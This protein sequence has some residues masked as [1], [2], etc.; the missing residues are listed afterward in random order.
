MLDFSMAMKEF[1]S[2]IGKLWSPSIGLNGE[3]LEKMLKT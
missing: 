1:T 3:E 2:W